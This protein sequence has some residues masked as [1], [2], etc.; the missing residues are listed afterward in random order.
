MISIL[1]PLYNGA[2]FLD[3]SV[4]SVIAQTHKDWELLIGINGHEDDKANAIAN[5]IKSFNDPRVKPIFCIKKGKSGTL[6]ELVPYTK[7]K[8]ICLLDVDDFWMETKLEQQ[9]L[10]IDK[11][12]VVGSDAKYFGDRVGSPGLFLGKLSELMFSWQNPIINSAIMMKKRDA[13]WDENWEGI[14]DYNLTI[15]LLKKEKTFY[16]VPQVLV[17]HRLHDSSFFNNKNDELAD[18]LRKEKIPKLTDEEYQN[19]M[20]IL[21]QKDWKL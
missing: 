21:E 12:D 16:N 6:N 1:M 11:Y 13:H 2:E 9:L 7:N 8:I 20:T 3:D 15:D 18:K 4:N 17:F 14:D 5:K 10:F 19:L